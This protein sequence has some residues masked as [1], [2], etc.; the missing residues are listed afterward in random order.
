MTRAWMWLA[1]FWLASLPVAVAAPA[2]EMVQLTPASAANGWR[3]P[4]GSRV[5]C[6]LE[7]MGQPVRISNASWQGGTRLLAAGDVDGIYPLPVDSDWPG[8]AVHSAPLLLERWVWLGPGGERVAVIGGTPQA[9]WLASQGQSVTVVADSKSQLVRL[10]L[11]GR[12]DQALVDEFALERYAGPQQAGLDQWPRRFERYVPLGVAFHQRHGSSALLPRFNREIPACTEG[13]F[14]LNGREQ[15]AVTA[16]VLP[17]LARLVA[18]PR[19]RQLL[20]QHQ[21]PP[22]T[23]AALLAEDQLW[24]QRRE[25]GDPLLAQEQTQGP[26]AERLQAFD[27]PWLGELFVSDNLGRAVAAL[28]LTSDLWQGDEDKFRLA[29][30]Q[31]QPL[32]ET[33]SYDASSHAFLVHVSQAIRQGEQTLGV[34]TLG[35]DMARLLK[36][37]AD[38]AVA[39]AASP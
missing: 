22:R 39:P 7:R 18:D 16:E 21:L 13:G 14:A 29:I 36:P 23:E 11:A 33:I 32:I 31:P 25:Q 20:R 4:A 3:E 12:I 38:A 27:Q 19:L 1:L 26:L 24:R 17:L 9:T 34:V 6:V 28:R 8:I 30:R 10:L 15:Q 37:E 2:L 5:R 35:V